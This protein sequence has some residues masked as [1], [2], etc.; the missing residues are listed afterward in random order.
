MSRSEGECADWA[1]AHRVAYEIAP[2]IEMRAGE[3]MQV[4]FSFNLYAEAAEEAA[5]STEVG[6]RLPRSLYGGTAK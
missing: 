6:E 1:R 2:L 4:G 3:K 5:E